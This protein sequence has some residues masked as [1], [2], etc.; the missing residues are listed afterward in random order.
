MPPSTLGFVLVL[1]GRE[2]FHKVTSKW[3]GCLWAWCHRPYSDSLCA[4]F[5]TVGFLCTSWNELVFMCLWSGRLSLGSCVCVWVCVCFGWGRILL[6]LSGFV[7]SCLSYIY[8]LHFIMNQTHTHPCVQNKRAALMAVY[9][10]QQEAQTSNKLY[11]FKAEGMARSVPHTTTH[12]YYYH[13]TYMAV[14]TLMVR[15]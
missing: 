3:L 13:T 2:A 8:P 10:K 7:L 14:E 11:A 6:G 5:F 12:Y 9:I 4:L 1:V 15:C